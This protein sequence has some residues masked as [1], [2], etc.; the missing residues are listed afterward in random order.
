VCYYG[1][2]CM[3]V[4]AAAAGLSA[5]AH[6]RDPTE[7]TSSAS[8]AS[9]SPSQK[10][11]FFLPS[12]LPSFLLHWWSGPCFCSLIGGG[13]W[14]RVSDDDDDM[15][16]MMMMMM[17][18]GCCMPRCTQQ[19]LSSCGERNAAIASV[20][21]HL[22]MKFLTGAT[23]FFLF[24]LSFNH[25]VRMMITPGPTLANSCR[26]AVSCFIFHRLLSGQGACALVCL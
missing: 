20:L 4:R 25:D 24:S 5:S 19:R 16:M 15:M 10:T 7:S 11:C 2:V 3:L 22:P 21:R 1:Y 26:S 13:G 23:R 9:T 17:N 14:L 8:A 18:V 6:I 12:F